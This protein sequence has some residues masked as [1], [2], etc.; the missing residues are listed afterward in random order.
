VHWHDHW[1]L[2]SGSYFSPVVELNDTAWSGGTRRGLNQLYMTLGVI[3][4]RF[5]LT[6]NTRFIIGGGHQFALSPH[7]VTA[8]LTPAYDHNFV[9]SAPR[10]PEPKDNKYR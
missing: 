3:F 1:G 8:P 6:H 2:T 4:G 9:L 10:I 5:Q 7:L